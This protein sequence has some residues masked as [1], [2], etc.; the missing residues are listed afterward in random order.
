MLVDAHS[1]LRNVEV[2]GSAPLCLQECPRVIDPGMLLRVSLVVFEADVRFMMLST[3]DQHFCLRALRFG[4]CDDAAAGQGDPS[5]RSRAGGL[6]V[7][8]MF[9]WVLAN[10]QIASCCHIEQWLGIRW[11]IEPVLSLCAQCV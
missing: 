11:T 8:T 4:T 7:L 9:C 3:A 6:V 10:N 5:L 1:L 2:G